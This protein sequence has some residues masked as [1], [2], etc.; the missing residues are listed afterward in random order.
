VV[1]LMESTPCENQNIVFI[2]SEAGSYG[3]RQITAYAAAKAGINALTKGLA[4][5]IGPLNIRV[6]AISPGLVANSD[7]LTEKVDSNTPIGRKAYPREIADTIFAVVN[8][9]TYINGA[10]IP[11][12]GGR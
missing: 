6:N 9:L 12:S 8:K 11:I 3:G 2:S 4:R 7:E 5:D 10:I 1:S